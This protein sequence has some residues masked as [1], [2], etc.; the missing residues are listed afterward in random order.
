IC[1][2]PGGYTGAHGLRPDLLTAGKVVAG[3][4]PMGILGLT[5]ETAERLASVVSGQLMGVAGVGGTLAGNALAMAAA[6]ATLSDVLTTD[7]YAHMTDRGRE[8]AGG[9]ATVIERHRLPWHVL[10]YGSRVEYAFRS[11]PSR[12]G[13]EAFGTRDAPIECFIHLYSLNRG[14]LV[15]PFHN[16]AMASPATSAAEVARHGEVF[17]GAVAAALGTG[18]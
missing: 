16:L 1:A 2:G 15:V 5:E 11:E 18:A 12:N 3:G 17:A 8:I 13:A 9:I 6:R 4:L 14:V 10:A 7:A